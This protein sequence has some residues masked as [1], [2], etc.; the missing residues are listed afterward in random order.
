MSFSFLK[1]LEKIIDNLEL[2]KNQIH[3][4]F[5]L[6]L[7]SNPHPKFPITILQ[8]SL[9]I[10]TEP[11]KTLKKNVMRLYHNMQEEK[12]TNCLPDLQKSAAQKLHYRKVLFSLCWFHSVIIERKKFKT[13]GW[14]VTYDFNDSDF[15]T[16]DN[17]LQNYIK[18]SAQEY[19]LF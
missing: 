13:L 17:I 19:W 6:F 1:E 4:N 18:L 11:P 15:D 2:T 3:E 8:K 9:R 5:R 10:T 7:T 16:A 14:N 12:F